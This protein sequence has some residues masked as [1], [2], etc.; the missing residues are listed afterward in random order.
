MRPGFANGVRAQHLFQRKGVSLVTL[1]HLFNPSSKLC[2][3]WLL[4]SVQNLKVCD[5]VLLLTWE[6]F[7]VVSP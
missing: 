2:Q 3:D 1:C 4:V 5:D 7:C 6:L